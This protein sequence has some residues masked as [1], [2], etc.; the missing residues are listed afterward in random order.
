MRR[1][2]QLRVDQHSMRKSL[3]TSAQC[4]ASRNEHVSSCHEQRKT[5]SWIAE[6]LHQEWTTPENCGEPLL[7]FGALA[8]SDTHPRDLARIFRRRAQTAQI[9]IPSP[10]EEAP[11]VPIS[12]DDANARR[13]QNGRETHL[14]H[15]DPSPEKKPIMPR[16]RGMMREQVG[17]GWGKFFL[18]SPPRTTCHSCA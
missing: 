8:T 10:R 7:W 16:L 4:A 2:A 9:P 18:L 11:G 15:N 14:R 13:L 5:T 6:L 17:G 3:N 1:H 12:H